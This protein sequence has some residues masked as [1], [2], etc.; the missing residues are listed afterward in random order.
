VAPLQT[1]AAQPWSRLHLD[2]AGLFINH[3]FLFIID[4]HTKW[5]EAAPLPV[6]TSQLTIQQL[7]PIF[8]H[9][10]IPDTVVTN[11]VTCF[12]SSEFEQFLF[13]NGIHHQKSSP[14]HPAT[15]GLAERAIH[16]LKQGLKMI[17]IEERLAK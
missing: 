17:K 11:N 15:N 10:G 2:F 13:V 16:I 7:Q 6:A 4:T 9:F 14:F 12:V 3:M 1:L 8:T 5:I